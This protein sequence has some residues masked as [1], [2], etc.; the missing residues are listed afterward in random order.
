ML[1]TV[2][3]Q[4][5][6][7]QR[8]HTLPVS[9]ELIC[10]LQFS[11]KLHPPKWIDERESEDFILFLRPRLIETKLSRTITLQHK[12]KCAAGSIAIPRSIHTT[13]LGAAH[14]TFYDTNNCF[15]H[16][17]PSCR[18]A[19]DYFVNIFGNGVPI[20]VNAFQ[21]QRFHLNAPPWHV[22]NNT[23]SPVSQDLVNLVKGPPFRHKGAFVIRFVRQHV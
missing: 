9:A 10:Q 14:R 17:M 8:L 2:T 11:V 21:S 3:Y 23:E 7:S 15:S 18:N 5:Y 6:L 20:Y 16:R 13:A 12:R 1:K 19:V 4:L 22:W